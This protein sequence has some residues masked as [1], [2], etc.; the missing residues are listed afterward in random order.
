MFFFNN[1][2]NAE[3]M[4]SDLRTSNIKIN[5]GIFLELVT[6]CLGYTVSCLAIP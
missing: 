2:D 1:T 5:H 6:F 4:T 3:H